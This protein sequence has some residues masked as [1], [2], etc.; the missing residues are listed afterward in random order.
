LPPGFIYGIIDEFDIRQ[1]YKV[2]SFSNVGPA[3]TTILGG[4]GQYETC[5]DCIAQWMGECP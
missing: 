3:T 4:G 2:L 5:Q 1:C